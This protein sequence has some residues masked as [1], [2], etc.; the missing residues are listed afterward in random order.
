MKKTYDVYV[1]KLP[2]EEMNM[3][4]EWLKNQKLESF[5]NITIVTRGD[6]LK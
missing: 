1:C 5:E 4:L 2:L 3:L 6:E